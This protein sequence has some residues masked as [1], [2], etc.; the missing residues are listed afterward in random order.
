MTQN[1]QA[2]N[3]EATRACLRCA[4]DGKESIM[5][6]AT[7]DSSAWGHTFTDESE[8]ILTQLMQNSYPLITMAAGEDE[9]LELCYTVIQPSL[10]TR[11]MGKPAG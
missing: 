2:I 7:E 6:A 1:W 9:Y 8:A 10:R 11:R 3:L 4:D 5:E